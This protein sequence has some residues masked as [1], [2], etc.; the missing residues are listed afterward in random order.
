MN[1]LLQ[2]AIQHHYLGELSEAE[3]LYRT[4]LQQ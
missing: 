3:K 2:Q 4:I 1:H